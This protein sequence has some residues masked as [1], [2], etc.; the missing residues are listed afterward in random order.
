MSDSEESKQHKYT[1]IAASIVICVFIICI[2]IA[3]CFE[4]YH[5][6]LPVVK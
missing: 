1:C 2:T 4:Y 5:T 3:K 6:Q